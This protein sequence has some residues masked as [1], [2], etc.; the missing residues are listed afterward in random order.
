MLDR[1]NGCPRE[2]QTRPTPLPQVPHGS[3][4][5]AHPTHHTWA[6]PHPYKHTPVDTMTILGTPTDPKK[7]SV[8]SKEGSVDTTRTEDVGV[9]VPVGKED[10]RC[11]RVRRGSLAFRIQERHSPP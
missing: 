3:P 9:L 10:G 7:S 6:T 11:S 8:E 4:E 5:P 2:S 1:V